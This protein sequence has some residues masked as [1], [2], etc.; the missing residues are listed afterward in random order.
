LPFIIL[1]KTI[2]KKLNLM[3]FEK[4]KHLGDSLEQQISYFKERKIFIEYYYKHYNK[5]K[6]YLYPLMIRNNDK[7]DLL[8]KKNY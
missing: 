2:E 1:E 5:H 3:D 4:L 7:F 6:K 8:E